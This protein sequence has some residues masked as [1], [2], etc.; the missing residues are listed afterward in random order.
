VDPIS[1]CV[2]CQQQLQQQAKED[3]LLSAL[4]WHLL[5]QGQGD[6]GS[7]QQDQHSQRQQRRWTGS[8][9]VTA[10]SAGCLL[11][12]KCQARDAGVAAM[13]NMLWEHATVVPSC[14]VVVMHKASVTC[15]V[16]TSSGCPSNMTLC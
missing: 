2:A 12:S 10:T 7:Q 9:V 4:Q 14:A 13:A 5:A 3:V 8:V 6:A 1:G 11:D 16:S 15:V